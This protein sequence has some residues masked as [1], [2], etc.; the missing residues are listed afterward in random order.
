M[1]RKP[2]PN[3]LPGPDDYDHEPL[4]KA[5][6]EAREHL[7]KYRSSVGNKVPA[8]ET[9]DTCI[10]YIDA[11]AKLTGYPNAEQVV[12]DVDFPTTPKI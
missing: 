11:F 12:H 5:L 6:K 2:S 4:L 8:R 3:F 9:A 7:V 10:N 1:P